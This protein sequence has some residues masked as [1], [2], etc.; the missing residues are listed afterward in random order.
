MGDNAAAWL[1]KIRQNPAL[2]IVGEPAPVTHLPSAPVL[3]AACARPV[4]AQADVLTLILPYP[5]S[6]NHYYHRLP[7][8]V[9]LRQA[10]RDYRQAVAVAVAQQ[11][12]AFAPL[13]GILA[14]EIE[15]HPLDL[16]RD[17]DNPEKALL[18]A[19]QHAGIYRNDRQIHDKHIRWGTLAEPPYVQV[20]L[21][22][23]RCPRAAP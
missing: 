1:T 13:T 20:T 23:L 9:V 11:C 21:T 19:L 12:R 17:I 22:E 10:G 15:A 7:D 5:P 2:R 4:T 6:I 8:R 18:D 14:M 3:C 16:D